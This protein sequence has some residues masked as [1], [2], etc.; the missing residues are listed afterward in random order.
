[1]KVSDPIS[2]NVT[3]CKRKKTKTQNGFIDILSECQEL[4][5]NSLR[6]D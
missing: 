1:M 3:N 4:I 5:L 6:S 2:K